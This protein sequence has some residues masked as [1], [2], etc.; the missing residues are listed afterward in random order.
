MRRR[1]LAAFLAVTVLTILLFGVPR[2]FI[3]AER[4]RD[5]ETQDVQRITATIAGVVAGDLRRGDDPAAGQVRPLLG[6]GDTATILAPQLDEPLVLGPG[7][8]VAPGA[9][10]N[11][12]TGIVA[13]VERPSGL[14]VTVERSDAA[15]RRRVVESLVSLGLVG[16][17]VTAVSA[18]VASV[19]ARVL[20]RP[21]VELA[22]DAGRLGHG[23]FDIRPTG[24]RLP[25]A[26]A[27]RDA[28]DQSARR[29]ADTLRREREFASNA[30]HQLRTPL[31]GLRLRLEDMTLWPEV[32][33]DVREELQAAIA[34]V[35]R[36]A[37]TVTGLL[38]L[39]RAGTYGEVEATSPADLL[40]AAAGRWRQIARDA[41]RELVLG[42]C[43]QGRVAVSAGAADEVLDVLVHN[44][45]LHGTGTVTLEAL[46]EDD[47]VRLRVRDEGPG[48]PAEQQAAVFER[49]GR[50]SQSQGEGIG[51]ALAR[52]LA[53][54][55]GGRLVLGAGAP[56]RFD[57]VL[58]RGS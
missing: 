28:L 12:S 16:L 29:L 14:A 49:H 13:S 56:T 44:A 48:V 46:G 32:G 7:R 21:F 27:V 50:G 20:A 45:L 30:S 40:G 52:D 26:V 51:L 33:D 35:D 17:A 2:A 6:P 25:E 8:G 11:G 42:P 10:A 55:A 22:E 54:A 39:G 24:S 34:Q 38:E 15:V 1:L 18:T 5:A 41:G 43:D 53:T 47:H 58:P 3:V 19:L 9:P 37:G 57:L 36:L 31:S 4:T 23:H